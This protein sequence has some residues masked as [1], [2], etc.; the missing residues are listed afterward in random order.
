MGNVA[1]DS[2]DWAEVELQRL[3]ADHASVPDP[4]PLL[5]WLRDNAPVQG[6][7]GVQFITRF[8]DAMFDLLPGSQT[9]KFNTGTAPMFHLPAP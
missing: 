1:R 2:R 9:V 5:A 3:F 4:Y 8:E 7:N 6:C